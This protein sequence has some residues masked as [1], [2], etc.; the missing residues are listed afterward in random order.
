[1]AKRCTICK[2][3]YL[4]FKLWQNGN[5]CLKINKPFTRPGKKSNLNP[6]SQSFPNVVM[7]PLSE[8]QRKHIFLAKK[9]Q[10]HG[11]SISDEWWGAISVPLFRSINKG[12]YANIRLFVSSLMKRFLLKLE[13]IF[14]AEIFSCGMHTWCDKWYGFT[15]FIC[16]F[17][18]YLMNNFPK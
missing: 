4:K 11:R 1:M 16:N 6:C 7:H 17:V 2:Y 9:K 5:S 3:R 12:Q 14:L 15:Y 10:L 13:I 18:L 8:F